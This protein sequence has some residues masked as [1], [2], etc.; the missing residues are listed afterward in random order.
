MSGRL[1]IGSA[2]QAPHMLQGLPRPR[3]GGVSAEK[4]NRH[5]VGQTRIRGTEGQSEVGCRSCLAPDLVMT[6][7]H[8]AGL[9]S[10]LLPHPMPRATEHFPGDPPAPGLGSSHFWK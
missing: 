2:P 8:R 1:V 4:A 3:A 9:R 6:T 7:H 10:F 5:G